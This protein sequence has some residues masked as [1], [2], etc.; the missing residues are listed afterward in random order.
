MP[1]LEQSFVLLL[2]KCSMGKLTGNEKIA[3]PDKVSGCVIATSSG[4]PHEYQTGFP[5]KIG[6]VDSTDF[7]IFDSGTC[8]SKNGELITNGG[9]VL[10]IVCQGKNFDMVFEKAYK[11]LKEISFDGIYFRNDIGHQVRTNISKEN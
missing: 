1:L 10:S 3:T 7:Q 6:K 11:N 4:Y 8:F 5:I 2:E 9:R